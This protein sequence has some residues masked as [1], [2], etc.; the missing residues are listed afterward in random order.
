[1]D[2][3]S[4]KFRCKRIN[5]EL[6]INISKINSWRNKFYSLEL[7]GEY[8]NGIGYGNIS[9]TDG[10]GFIITGTRTGGIEKLTEEHYTKVVHWDFMKNSLTCIG[11]IKASSESLTHA[12][13][14]E[15]DVS[16]NAVIHVHNRNLWKT[17]MNN[18]PTTSGI[19]KYGTPEMAYEIRRL[20]NETDV[21][22]KKILVMGGH[23]EGIISF[24]RSLDEAGKTLLDYFNE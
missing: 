19:V 11:K 4:V 15:S 3:G 8:E 18:I 7:I 16:I 23:K 2:E 9:I 17:L 12:A 20:F 1:M 22:E 10:G 21:K 24:G 6:S 5:S 14:Y 13:I